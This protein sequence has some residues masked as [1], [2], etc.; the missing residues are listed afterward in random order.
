MKKNST[1]GKSFKQF[2]LICVLL[3][4]AFVVETAANE[5]ELN[6]EIQTKIN[7]FLADPAEDAK[8]FQYNC[9]APL[10]RSAIKTSFICIEGLNAANNEFM[11]N[12]LTPFETSK[13]VGNGVN[14]SDKDEDED[15]TIKHYVLNFIK[16][17]KH[18]LSDGDLKKSILINAQTAAKDFTLEIDETSFE[19]LN[20]IIFSIGPLVDKRANNV[21]SL[22]LDLTT[23]TI[24]FKTNFFENTFSMSMRHAKFI[25]TEIIR[26]IKTTVRD[27]KRMKQLLGH[28][29]AQKKTINNLDCTKI[30]A[31]VYVQTDLKQAVQRIP[32]W[33]IE[34]ESTGKGWIIKTGGLEQGKI[35]C[36]DTTIDG[37]V[38]ISRLTFIVSG[39]KSGKLESSQ[40]VL[41]NSMYDLNAVADTFFGDSYTDMVRLFAK[42]NPDE[43]VDLGKD[44]QVLG[45]GSEINENSIEKDNSQNNSGISQ[46]NNEDGSVLKSQDDLDGNNQE[47]RTLEK[48]KNE[49]RK[50]NEIAP[51]KLSKEVKKN[52]NEI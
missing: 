30:A 49:S 38:G 35:K 12:F 15:F 16:N 40:G 22:K 10:E 24:T 50:N 28:D 27:L 52:K 31:A 46:Q 13:L 19:S 43:K 41:Q 32:G 34:D 17:A 2:Q 14:I 6:T 37:K 9:P 51:S 25:E 36:E 11:I 48:M 39:A 20:E 8:L 1:S 42:E 33:S 21:I 3:L 29:L 45:S 18:V 7:S 4:L 5:Q 47:R 23:M 44:A 26:A